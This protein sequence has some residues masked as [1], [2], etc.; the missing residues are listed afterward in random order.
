MRAH[1]GY[2]PAG[3]KADPKSIM[4]YQE[5]PAR[6]MILRHR[7]GPIRKDPLAGIHWQGS[8]GR[9][10]LA[11]I[12]WQGST[13]RDLRRGIRI[14]S[15]SASTRDP[16]HSS[17]ATPNCTALPSTPQHSP[18]LP[19]TPK[20]SQALPSTNACALPTTSG[21]PLSGWPLWGWPL[22][23]SPMCLTKRGGNPR[24][25]RLTKP[26]PHASVVRSL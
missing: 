24:P 23:G 16:T 14:H 7:K 10:P 11:G 4:G 20:H 26:P 18:A 2:Q 21:W 13:G 1:P 8:T 15:R 3:I 25:G 19:S 5:A 12:H 22:W 9:D 6:A 17:Y